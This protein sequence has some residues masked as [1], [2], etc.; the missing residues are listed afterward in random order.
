LRGGGSGGAQELV[1]LEKEYRPNGGGA[2]TKRGGS[3]NAEKTKKQQ[4]NGPML[5][6]VLD[7]TA[8]LIT[9]KSEGE[10][11]GNSGGGKTLTN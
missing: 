6:R 9:K 11:R 4:L 1:E 2:R 7:R 10:R 5:M 3:T 8:V